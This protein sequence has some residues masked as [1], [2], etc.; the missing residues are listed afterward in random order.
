MTNIRQICDA[1][2]EALKRLPFTTA[3]CGV[4]MVFSVNKPDA[5]IM[6]VQLNMA[7]ETIVLASVRIQSES[8]EPLMTD[9]DNI[10]WEDRTDANQIPGVIYTTYDNLFAG[11]IDDEDFDCEDTEVFYMYSKDWRQAFKGDTVVDLP[12]VCSLDRANNEEG[13]LNHESEI[14]EDA[15][16]A[17]CVAVVKTALSIL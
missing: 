15:K 12:D 2:A 9:G 13:N 1:A 7:S 10:P 16:C 5:L 14:I 17:T 8:E 6:L 3:G 11:C 4:D